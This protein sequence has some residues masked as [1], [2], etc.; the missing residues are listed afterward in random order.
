MSKKAKSDV[1]E[2]ATRGRVVGSRILAK[3]YLNDSMGLPIDPGALYDFDH[4]GLRVL[5]IVRAG[6]GPPSNP[7]PL[8]R[9]RQFA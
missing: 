3:D 9:K 1:P 8:V 4:I 2:G 6:F 7:K 5:M